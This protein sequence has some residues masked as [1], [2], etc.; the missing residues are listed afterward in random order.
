[1]QT[2]PYYVVCVICKVSVLFS[3]LYTKCPWYVVL[4]SIQNAHVVSVYCCS[5]CFT[6]G[7]VARSGAVVQALEAQSRDAA[8]VHPWVTV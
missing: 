3:N 8:G 2:C 1:M 7:G 4:L 6:C 5:L